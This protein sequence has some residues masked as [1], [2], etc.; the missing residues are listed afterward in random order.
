[1]EGN[2]LCCTLCEKTY[3]SVKKRRAHEKTCKG[4]KAICTQCIPN[5]NFSNLITFKKHA[6]QEHN[7]RVQLVF[8]MCT[9]C[10]VTFADAKR[11]KEH[12]EN[13]VKHKGVQTEGLIKYYD[14]KAIAFVNSDKRKCT[15]ENKE[16]VETNH[17]FNKKRKTIT[18][19]IIEEGKQQQPALT[20]KMKITP[21]FVPNT[22]WLDPFSV[23]W[24]DPLP[25]LAKFA[26]AD[27]NTADILALEVVDQEFLGDDFAFGILGPI[28]D[29]KNF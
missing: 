12:L 20:L 13:T 15:E 6:K 4:P 29:F 25:P 9:E 16:I 26:T 10:K 28:Q 5:K 2:C 23:D 8:A 17:S 19:E 1:M 27:T 7:Q 3:S 24:L 22:D 14:S 18:Q 11:A 21:T